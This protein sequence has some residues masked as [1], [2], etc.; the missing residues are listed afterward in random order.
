[1]NTRAYTTA[2]QREIKNPYGANS[3]RGKEWR[4]QGLEDDADGMGGGHLAAL[5]RMPAVCEKAAV[6]F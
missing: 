3:I 2:L 6:A 4:K 1:M 5:P